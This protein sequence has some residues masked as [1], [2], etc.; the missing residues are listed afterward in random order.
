MSTQIYFF[1][2]TIFLS[3]LKHEGLVLEVCES[4]FH[5]MSRSYLPKPDE[6]LVLFAHVQSGVFTY[7]TDT[8]GEISTERFVVSI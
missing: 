7:N 4:S 5:C 6:Y 3:I 2:V 1:Q 8:T